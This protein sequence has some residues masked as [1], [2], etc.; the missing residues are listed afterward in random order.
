MRWRIVV[1]TEVVLG[2]ASRGV[3]R[4]DRRCCRTRPAVPRAMGS[5]R[6]AAHG[7]V[8][9][10]PGRCTGCGEQRSVPHSCGH[11]ACPHCQHHEA[12]VWIERQTPAPGDS[13]PEQHPGGPAQRS[14]PD[15]PFR[16]YLQCPEATVGALRHGLVQQT[17][18][19]AA[20]RDLSL[21]VRRQHTARTDPCSVAAISSMTGSVPKLTEPSHLSVFSDPLATKL[22]R[23]L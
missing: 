8:L 9:L 1:T 22:V 15:W 7:R 11:R 16:M 2:R 14:P 21:I 12:Q 10:V 13:V 19:I 20:S 6:H 4:R 23:S 17:D 18:Q 5:A 3:A